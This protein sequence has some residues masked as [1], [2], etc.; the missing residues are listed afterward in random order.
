MH[1]GRLHTYAY[2]VLRAFLFLQ[3]YI[4]DCLG[5]SKVGFILM[6]FGL[7]SGAIC[8]IYGPIVKYIPECIVLLLGCVIQAGLIIF[9]LLWKREPSYAAVIFFVVGWGAADAVW[10]ITYS[11]KVHTSACLCVMS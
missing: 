1:N 10:Q 7:S 6:L 11:G 5:V 2:C 9:L 3:V 8:F 4:S